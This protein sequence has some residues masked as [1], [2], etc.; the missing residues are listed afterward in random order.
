M[1]DAQEKDTGAVSAEAVKTDKAE[2]KSGTT[3]TK[4]SGYGAFLTLVLIVVAVIA[5][6]V[7]IAT[8]GKK[9]DLN[10]YA[11]IKVSGYNTIGTAQLE[12]DKEKF[13]KDFGDKLKI[14]KGSEQQDLMKLFYS[15]ASNFFVDAYV[16]GS[17][18]KSRELSNGD[19]IVYTWNVDEDKIK[20][21]FGYKVVCKDIKMTVKG[22]EEIATFDPFE[23]VVVEF[24]GTAPNGTAAVKNNSTSKYA[25]KLTFKLDTTSG[26]SNGDTVTVKVND[27]NSQNP[28]Q[29]FI[30][31]C[32]AVPSTTEKQFTVS[33]LSE[34]INSASKIPEDNMNTMKKQAEDV[35]KAYVA[36]NWSEESHMDSCKY[37]GN[38]FTS[39][40]SGT[41][42]NNQ[43]SVYLVYKIQATI[44]SE[45]RE[46]NDS[47]EFYT[48]VKFSD[49]LM[50][51]DG[52]FSMDVSKY[53]MAN[54]TFTKTYGSG[55]FN[56][57][58]YYVKGYE[59]LD[60]MFNRTIATDVD[61]YNYE[62]N[63]AE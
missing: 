61:R 51:A 40:K 36:K 45:K 34:Y 47:F 43:N 16:S 41:R 35:I 25:S 42:V 4:K 32:E 31:L 33:G 12:F 38:Y 50:L 13:E 1:S 21:V 60:T 37:V 10:K 26:L 57:Y 29:Y 27:G 23:G 7:M 55:F 17:F 5:A 14:K 49:M 11:T 44:N 18:D 62:D 28:T 58:N 20:E 63:I 6:I 48:Y 30:N 46:I 53:A 22:L 59:L 15:S 3:G 19:K 56:S 52:K 54:D 24:N 39:A 2:Q 9:I 8:G